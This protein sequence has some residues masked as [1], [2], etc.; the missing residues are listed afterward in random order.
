MRCLDGIT[1]SNGYELEQ[2]LGDSE[3]QGSL[4]CYSPWGHKELDMTEQL[5][6]NRTWGVASQMALMVKN[7]PANAGDSR[8]TVS[9]HGSGRSPGVGNGNPLRYILGKFHGQRS[10]TG[11]SPWGPKE[12]D[13]NDHVCAHTH[14]H[15]PGATLILWPIN[16]TTFHHSEY[17]PGSIILYYTIF[18]LS[19]L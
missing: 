13:M 16:N 7:P 14:T 12:S 6:N 3:E 15:T 18:K 17:G 10:L 9:I 5:N 8:D 4:V 11:Y 1:D 19:I 2:T